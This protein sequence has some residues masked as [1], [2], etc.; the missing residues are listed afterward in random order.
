DHQRPRRAARGDRGEQEGG[1]RH[2]GVP[3]V[4]EE[5]GGDVP[6]AAEGRGRRR[7]VA[8]AVEEG[9]RE[10]V[11]RREGVPGGSGD[12]VGPGAVAEG[13]EGAAGG[14]PVV[15]VQVGRAGRGGGASAA[16]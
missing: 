6:V 11:P 4:P 16:G 5:G 8:D 7:R 13:A 3:V 1:D 12:E 15:G 9:R 2:P 10:V 14:G